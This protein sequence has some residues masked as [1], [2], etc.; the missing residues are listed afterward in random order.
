MAKTDIPGVV[1]L[2]DGVKSRFDNWQNALTGLGTAMRD[3]LQST[4]FQ[5]QANLSDEMVETLYHQEDMAARVVEALPEG[6]L[7]RGYT[8]IVEGEEASDIPSDMFEYEKGLK[9]R[10]AL[11]EAA[12]WGRCF[13][14]AVVYLGI[15]DGQESEAEP[16]NEDSIRSITFALVLTKR[17]LTPSTYYETTDEGKLGEPETYRL[18]TLDGRQMD[19]S[20]VIHETRLLRMGGA[21]TSIRRRRR[22]NGWD[23]S[24][25]QKVHDVLIKFNIGWASTAHILQDGAQGVFKIRGLVDMIADGDKETLNNRMELV[26]MGRGVARAIMVDAELEDFQRAN[27]NYGGLPDVLRTFMLRLA[28]AARMPVTMLMGQAPSGLNATGESDFRMWYDQIEDYQGETILPPVER[29][30]TLVFKAQDFPHEAPKRWSVKFHKLWQLND[31]EQA[32]LEKKVAEKDKIYI[33]SQVLL[34]EEV[35]LNRFKAVGFSMETQIDDD[36]REEMLEAEIELAKKRA[37]E[38]PLDAINNPANADPA[39]TNP[40]GDPP[41]EA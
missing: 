30:H 1:D 32:D 10:S 38:D 18:S 5:A 15:D 36:A 23:D 26:E 19:G 37:K 2:I 11:K 22:N 4:T 29:L 28:A 6:A 9:F 24:V 39:A 21:R 35:A 20:D 3:K 41:A 27:F 34:P 13:G 14:G 33:D 7:R 16:V 12:I 17:E 25:L 40:G 31:V 8:V